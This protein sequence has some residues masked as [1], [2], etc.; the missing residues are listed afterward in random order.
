M[1]KYRG[2]LNKVCRLC[3]NN[4][5]DVH[6]EPSDI[7][8]VTVDNKAIRKPCALCRQTRHIVSKVGMSGKVKIFLH[9]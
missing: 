4:E 6:L 5:F 3:L 1:E 2:L 7:V 8:Y 9:R